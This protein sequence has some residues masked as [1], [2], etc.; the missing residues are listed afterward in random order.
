MNEI[1]K[2]KRYVIQSKKLGEPLN[3]FFDLTDAESFFKIKNHRIVK[4]VTQ[5]TELM[6]V[7]QIVQKTTNERLGKSIKQMTP[8]FHEIPEHYFFH[9]VCVSPDL[10]MPLVVIYFSDVKIGIFATTSSQ[11]DM[12]RFSLINVPDKKEKH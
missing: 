3:Y 2:L 11:T 1:E 10:V 12:V 9:G 6:T 4:D 5:N 8:L 7:L